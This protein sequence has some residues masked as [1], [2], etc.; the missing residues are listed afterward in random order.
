MHYLLSSVLANV[1]NI[2]WSG[3]FGEIRDIRKNSRNAADSGPLGRATKFVQTNE[4]NGL[5]VLRNGALQN[6]KNGKIWSNGD[7]AIGGHRVYEC[8]G[9]WIH[10]IDRSRC[11]WRQEW[12]HSVT[13]R[14]SLRRNFH[15]SIRFQ[16]SLVQMSN[17]P[18]L[19]VLHPKLCLLYWECT[20]QN[21]CLSQKNPQ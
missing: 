2:L 7:I 8:E 6:R 11:A 18:W 3:R 4:G 20:I 21:L 5:L 10:P 14:R 12:N 17:R 1:L 15:R 9:K 16:Y 19:Q 13:R